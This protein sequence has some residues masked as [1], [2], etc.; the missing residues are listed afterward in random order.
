M[1]TQ[2]RT[3]SHFARANQHTSISLPE[4]VRNRLVAT[5]QPPVAN[6]HRSQLTV[7]TV[8]RTLLLMMLALFS[9]ASPLTTAQTDAAH[10]HNALDTVP[11]HEAESPDGCSV[12]VNPATI[13]NPAFIRAWQAASWDASQ[14]VRAAISARIPKEADAALNATGQDRSKSLGSVPSLV[15]ISGAPT[16]RFDAAGN[17]L[18]RVGFLPTPK[19]VA[20]YG[21]ARITQDAKA[22]LVVVNEQFATSGVGVV[23]EFGAI[24]AYSGGIDEA[25]DSLPRIHTKAQ[26]RVD[27]EDGYVEGNYEKLLTF[28]AANHINLAVMLALPEKNPNVSGVTDRGF[29]AFRMSSFLIVLDPSRSDWLTTVYSDVLTHEIGH[30]MGLRHGIDQ[31]LTP[32]GLDKDP[33]SVLEYQL[34]TNYHYGVGATITDATG[35]GVATMMT[36]GWYTTPTQFPSTSPVFL[37]RFSDA[38]VTVDAPMANGTLKKFALG[39]VGRADAALALRR[40]LRSFAIASTPLLGTWLVDVVEYYHAGLNQY[41]MTARTDEIETLDRLGE[42]RTGLKRTG[43]SFKASSAWGNPTALPLNGITV[44]DFPVRRFYG[45]PSGPNTHFYTANTIGRG[46]ETYDAANHRMLPNFTE[47]K[48]LRKIEIS[49]PNYP[50]KLHFETTDFRVAGVFATFGSLTERS[51]LGCPSEFFNLIAPGEKMWTPIY[52][53]YNGEDGSRKRPDGSSID[54]NHRYT[55]NPAVIN[56]MLAKGWIHEGIAWCE[57][58]YERR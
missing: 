31:D 9:L 3:R 57:R 44:S 30:T 5:L 10:M 58:T 34:S 41:F 1:N 2:T 27:Y 26:A 16:L 4:T 55:Q 23:F 32:Y 33:D 22:A 12:A 51:T 39:S 8:L 52:R 48:E 13:A 38:S 46:G 15:P 53:F 17:I 35:A 47:E 43:E 49:N 19:A 54:G 37:R 42:A 6:P 45:H 14:K 21:I 25:L 56:E 50:H 20:K 24:E 36:L 28:R 7:A 40:E 29:D 18:L 11:L